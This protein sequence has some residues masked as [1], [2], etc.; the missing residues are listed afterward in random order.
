[1]ANIRDI[2]REAGVALSTV[3]H[4][5]NDTRYVSPELRARVQAAADRLGYRRNGLARS[6][7]TNRTQTIALVIPDIAN[8]YYPALARGVQ[9]VADAARFTTVVCNSDR[10]AAKERAIADALFDRRVDGVVFSPASGD[11]G[12]LDALAE[13]DRPVVLIG[14]RV[15]DPRFDVVMTAP[16]GAYEPVRHLA[17]LGHRRI[18]LVGG[19][20]GDA[21]PDKFTG[22]AAGLADAGLAVDDELVVA[23]DYTQAGGEA[24]AAALMA[25]PSPPTAIV[26]ANDLM[27]IGSLLWLRRAGYEVPRDVSVVG[28]DDIPQASIVSPPLTTVAV[29]KY[30][31]GRVAADLLR[32]RLNGDGGERRRVVLPHRLIVR[33]STGPYAR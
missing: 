28:F 4:V 11:R 32:Q 8:P 30:E 15:D 20:S 3:S 21:R 12:V 16:R 18:A 1:M 29:P 31:M 33:G 17:A 23:G 13:L 22:Y 6:L 2:A 7:R 9:D 14:S 26:A 27:A 5:L 10:S 25:R 19:R 24:A